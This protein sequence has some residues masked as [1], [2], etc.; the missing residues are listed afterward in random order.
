MPQYAIGEKTPKL[1]SGA[2]IA[3]NATVIGDV[4]LGDN[5]SIWF[6]A[7]LRGDN[8]PI[9]IGK[10][11]NIQD[12]SVLHT[13]IGA[14][15]TV[16][17]NVTVGHMVMLHGCTVGD[18]SLIGIKSVILNRAVIGKSCLIGANTLIPEGK[19]IPDRSL[20]MGS[21][22]KVV[23][24]LTDQEVA[25]LAMSAAHYVENAKRYATDLKVLP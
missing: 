21:P 24:E 16:G 19:V 15:L 4:R 17:E 18:G 10:N 25:S 20:V 14:P 7:V 8:D 12:G 22:G 5:A 23:R 11:S 6:S 1:G 13:D 3:D 9:S 2:W